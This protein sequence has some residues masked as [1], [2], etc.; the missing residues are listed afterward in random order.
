MRAHSAELIWRTWVDNVALNS[1]AMRLP[2]YEGVFEKRR[3]L[4]LF[5]LKEYDFNDT[6]ELFNISDYRF[7]GFNN[8]NCEW[9]GRLTG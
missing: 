1:G 4:N 2:V 7:E 3:R 8:K 5:D 9:A 6:F